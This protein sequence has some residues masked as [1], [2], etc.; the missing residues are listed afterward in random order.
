MD[1]TVEDKQI[2]EKLKTTKEQLERDIESF[3]F[4]KALHDLYDFF[5][6]DFCDVY[7]EESKKQLSEGSE[8]LKTTKEILSHVLFESLKML[9]LFL[10]FVTETIYQKLPVA[11]RKKTLMIEEWGD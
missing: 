5:W 10:P 6:H 1:L 8:N 2:L 7:L 4:A 3:E 9:H 11:E